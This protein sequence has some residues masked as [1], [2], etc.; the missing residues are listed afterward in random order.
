MTTN[1]FRSVNEAP[2]GFNYRFVIDH[3]D[4]TTSADNT[5]QD[6]T[7]ITLPAYSVVKSAATYLKTPFEKTGTAAYNTNVLIVGDSGDTDRFIASQ[8]LNVN[9][10]EI[11]AKANAASTVPHA[12]AT[13]TAVVANFASMASYDLAEL[14]AGEVHIFLEVAQL[15]SLT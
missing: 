14:D 1:I 4:L 15:D 10:T 8:E 7:L 3:T 2:R 6:I 12:Y 5:A 13:A 11:L 9:G